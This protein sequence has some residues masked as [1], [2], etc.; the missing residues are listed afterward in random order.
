MTVL[1]LGPTADLPSEA[2]RFIRATFG[3]AAIE[4]IS[5]L[6]GG[7]SGARVFSVRVAGRSYVLRVP[8]PDRDSHEQ[9]SER[10]ITG[11]KLAAERGIGPELCH[12]ERTTG[13]T[14]SAKI[15]GMLTGAERARAPGR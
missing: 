10:E 15:E 14:L 8:S 13:I 4:E 3:A 2:T 7:R 5:A 9:R 11:M 1:D 6:P 12:A